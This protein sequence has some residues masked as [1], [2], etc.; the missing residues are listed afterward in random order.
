MMQTSIKLR[1]PHTTD[2]L[3]SV[4]MLKANNISNNNMSNVSLKNTVLH[5]TY[6]RFPRY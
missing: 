4:F 1:V 5:N 2:V 6:T 3:H